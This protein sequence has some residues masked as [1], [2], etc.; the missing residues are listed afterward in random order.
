MEEE[1]KEDFKDIFK[2]TQDELLDLIDRNNQQYSH[3]NN[4]LNFMDDLLSQG[5]SD[6][7]FNT[8]NN[9]NI[10]PA[11][12]FSE[13]LLSSKSSVEDKEEEFVFEKK[14]KEQ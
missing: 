10:N 1:L 4:A 13:D 14:S 12:Q 2:V 11:D 8:A 9:K 3:N 6:N 7:N 5:G